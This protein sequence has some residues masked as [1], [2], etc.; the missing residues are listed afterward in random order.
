MTV[1]ELFESEKID[2]DFMWE[3]FDDEPYWVSA[4]NFIEEK[5][6]T[7]IERLSVKQAAWCTRI[8]DDCIEKRLSI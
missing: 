2:I 4:K 8:L 7:E 1:S 5:W 6:D 3:N